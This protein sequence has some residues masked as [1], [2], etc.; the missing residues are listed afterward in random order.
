MAKNGDCQFAHHSPRNKAL[1]LK[2]SGLRPKYSPWRG[3]LSE[4]LDSVVFR[5]TALFGA[6]RKEVTPRL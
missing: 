5:Q 3:S 1:G 2:R 6:S 4:P